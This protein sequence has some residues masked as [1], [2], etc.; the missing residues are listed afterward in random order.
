MYDDLS[1]CNAVRLTEAD[2]FH[3]INFQTYVFQG[4]MVNQFKETSYNCEPL[5]N[6]TY[7]CIYLSNLAPQ[8][9]INGTAVLEAYGYPLESK[10]SL[11]WIG[12]VIAIIVVYRLLGTLALQWRA[13]RK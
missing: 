13:G 3:Y 6:G 7:H 1:T 9:K 12:I 4:M 8:G 10:R 2:A 11:E 5:S